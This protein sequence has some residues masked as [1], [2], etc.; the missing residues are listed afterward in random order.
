MTYLGDELALVGDGEFVRPFLRGLAV[1]PDARKLLTRMSFLRKCQRV[2]DDDAGLILASPNARVPSH[3]RRC[4]LILFPKFESRS[5]LMIEPLSPAEALMRLMGC[6][7]NARNLA[8]H[9]VDLARRLAL[10]T[11]AISVRYG[12]VS[13]LT[14]VVDRMPWLVEAGQLT[15]L[16]LHRFL[17]AFR[18]RAPETP[19]VTVAAAVRPILPATPRRGP[20][21]LTLGMATYDDYDG[22]YFTIQALRLY[23]PEVLAAT[24]ILV[25]DNH[26][27]GPGAEPLKALENSIPN[28]RYVP[29]NQRTGTA[30]A[31]NAVFEEADGTYVLCLD[32]HVLVARDGLRRLL[33]YLDEF[34]ETT[35]LL[36][37]PLVYD[38][39]STF[40]SHLKP[41]WRGGMFGTWDKDP[42]ATDIDAAPFE[43]P[44][45]GMGLFACRRDAWLGFN[46]EFSGFG[47]EEGYIHEKFRQA[48]RRVLCLPFLRWLHRFNRPLGVPYRNNWEDRMRN[49]V[50]G[51]AELGIPTKD[52]ELHF[53]EL[54]GESVAERILTDIWA[55]LGRTDAAT[56]QQ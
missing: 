29:R 53:K 20:A 23:H 19:R 7:L 40:S 37:G 54:L 9:G 28:Y 39:L 21:K 55:E 34:P 30:T 15:P 47:G 10:T 49:Y 24:E 8:D 52:F 56:N 1:K 14:G 11:P 6:N 25:V 32:C 48:G 36:H 12:D 41:D 16:D 27:D 51:F 35:D 50:I 13:D 17:S 3:R 2:S 44:M 33:A 46:P 22:V 31:K 4:R 42:R 18:S 45:Q 5:Q 38:D 43:I 26:P